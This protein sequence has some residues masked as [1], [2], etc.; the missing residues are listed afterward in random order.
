MKHRLNPTISNNS[1]ELCKPEKSTLYQKY[2]IEGNSILKISMEL[3]YTQEKIS[4]LLKKHKIPIRSH[5]ESSLGEKNS[6]WKGGKTLHEDGHVLVRKP[7]HPHATGNG[8]IRRSRLV[9]EKHLGRYLKREEI[10]HHEKEKDDDRIENLRLF[11][12][13]SEHMSYHWQLR[14][15][16]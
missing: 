3:G 7:G 5:R 14:R 8:Y 1:Q 6:Q 15:H 16:K 2:I 13:V 10:V 9:M 12:G 4:S 11:P